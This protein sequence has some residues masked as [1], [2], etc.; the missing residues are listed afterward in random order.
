MISGAARLIAH[1]SFSG[2]GPGAAV[3]GG[4]SVGA[5]GD[6]DES[7]AGPGVLDAVESPEVQPVAVNTATA[8]TAPTRVPIATVLCTSAHR[9]GPPVGVPAG[10]RREKPAAGTRLR[11]R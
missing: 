2:G 8:A 4:G 5:D 6:G 1:G 9:T 3:A 11:T 7:A 10:A